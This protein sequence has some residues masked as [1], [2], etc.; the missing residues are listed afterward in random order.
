MRQVSNIKNKKIYKRETQIRK[1]KK[2]RKESQQQP[3][4][5]ALMV[6]T[7]S[8][9]NKEQR[10]QQHRRPGAKR[11]RRSRADKACDWLGFS[12]IINRMIYEAYL[13]PSLLLPDAIIISLLCIS[14]SDMASE[15]I[16]ESFKHRIPFPLLL[17][18][19]WLY[20]LPIQPTPWL[21][22][23]RCVTS[24]NKW[25]GTGEYSTHDK[26]SYF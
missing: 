23:G 11:S 3:H 13:H 12:C 5:E 7:R 19:L 26:Y 2:G 14:I 20:F 9:S 6:R 8:A 25:W 4:E 21:V 16:T 1:V 24:N 18:R 10:Q 17:F 22:N 15:I